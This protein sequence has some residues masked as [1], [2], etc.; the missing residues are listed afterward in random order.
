MDLNK[1]VEGIFK[2]Q[3]QLKKTIEEGKFSPQC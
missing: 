1:D 3:K 2:R